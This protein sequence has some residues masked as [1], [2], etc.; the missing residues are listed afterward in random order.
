MT[1]QAEYL[2]DALHYTG[3]EQALRKLVLNDKLATEE[4]L[5]LLTQQECAELIV[6]KYAVIST[7]DE[8]IT[9]YP[10]DKMHEYNQNVRYLER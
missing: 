8:C 3:Q 4:E 10:K 6:T 1:T 7:E 9:L 2:L 5:A